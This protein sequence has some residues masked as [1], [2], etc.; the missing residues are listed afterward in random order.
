MGLKQITDALRTRLPQPLRS[1]GAR[2]L[3]WPENR[4]F[5]AASRAYRIEGGY[6]R[7]YC[8]H[9]RK[10]AGTSLHRAFLAAS[11]GDGEALHEQMLATLNT[12]IIHN[13]IAYAGQNRTLIEAGHY[14][15]GYSHRPWHELKLPDGTFRISVL[16]DPVARVVSH[17]RMLIG[18]R[19]S[20]D[21]PRL[22]ANEGRWLGESID[23][24]VTLAPRRSILG[25]LYMFSEQLDVDQAVSRLGQLEYVFMTERFSEGL[26]ELGPRL[27]LELP[28]YRA[29][30]ATSRVEV[31][32]AQRQRIRALVA[33][34]YE[35]LGRLGLDPGAP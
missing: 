10:T 17:Y 35:M 29:R 11:G 33:P 15:Y 22:I 34:E 20:G 3:A 6:R 32:D 1:A 8:F 18:L 2:I 24:F 7:V 23:D 5:E 31:T 28:E 19:K 9:V 25:Q 14:F 12:R 21:D 13:G 16:R 27:G 4:R 26:A 30:I